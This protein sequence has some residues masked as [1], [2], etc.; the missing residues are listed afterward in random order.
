MAS[1]TGIH[2][3]YSV[4]ADISDH[5]PLLGRP[6]DVAQKEGESVVRNLITGYQLAALVW[7]GVLSQP[8]SL[9]SPHPMLSIS[10]V[11][12]QVQAALIVQ[13]TVTPAQK[14]N[15]ARIH[16]AIQLLSVACFISAF[17]II[18][19]NKGDHPHFTSP[20][21]I[22]GLTTYICIALQTLGGVVQFFVPSLVLGSVDAGKRL[23]KYHR[24]AGYVVLL[25]EMAVVVAATQTDYN[26]TTL[27]IPLWATLVAIVL[28]LAGVGARIKKHKLGF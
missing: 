10:A 7:S 5:E 25:L 13:P 17:T 3:D 28:I 8:L 6:G 11:L 4:V 16:A 12:L 1:T 23:Y 27:R 2:Q 19:L 22:L 26:L 14:H 21:G 20:H 24:I 18:E 9:F 15:G